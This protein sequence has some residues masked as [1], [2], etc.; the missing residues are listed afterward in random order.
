[1]K[2]TFMINQLILSKKRKETYQQDKMKI[3]LQDDCM[4]NH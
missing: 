3:R 2:T 4:K 1:M